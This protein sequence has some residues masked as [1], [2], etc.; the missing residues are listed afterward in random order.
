MVVLET[1][2]IFLEEYQFE[3]KAEKY[4][5]KHFAAPTVRQGSGTGIEIVT[6]KL[7][8]SGPSSQG[9]KSLNWIQIPRMCQKSSKVA[10][11]L[12]PVRLKVR[13]SESSNNI[14]TL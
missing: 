9:Y 10:G 7:H 12:L 2:A 3:G 4:F 14:P 6:E 8:G 5:E 1:K 11:T 13:C